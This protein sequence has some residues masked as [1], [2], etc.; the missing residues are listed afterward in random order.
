MTMI[1]S[2]CIC[3]GI[4]VYLIFMITVKPLILVGITFQVLL[5]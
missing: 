5:K 1:A 2:N 3:A 4:H